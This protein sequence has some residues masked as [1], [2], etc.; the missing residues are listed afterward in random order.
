MISNLDGESIGVGDCL[1]R[2]GVDTEVAQNTIDDALD[3]IKVLR[4]KLGH[5]FVK[6]S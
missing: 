4:A 1:K 2:I 5:I 6:E 3:V